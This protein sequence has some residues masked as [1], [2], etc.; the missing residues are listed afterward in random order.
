[1]RREPHPISGF[2]YEELGDGMVRVEDRERGRQGLFRW[3]G[4]WVEG[5]L[6]QWNVRNGNV[7]GKLKDLTQDVTISINIWSSVASRLGAFKQGDRVIAAVKPDYWVKGGSLSMQ[8]YDMRHVGLGDLLERL[9]RLKRQLASE[10]LFDVSRI[11]GVPIDYFYEGVGA[12]LAG[13]EGFAEESAPPVMEFVSSGEG[14]QL[15]L[16]FMKIKDA[17]VR[18]RVLDLVKSLGEEEADKN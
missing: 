13:Q 4:T 10:G 18:K 5:E 14:L 3:D 17:K 1:M 7:Y 12:H 2:V 16:A 11:L 15:S 9:E 6:T 8:V